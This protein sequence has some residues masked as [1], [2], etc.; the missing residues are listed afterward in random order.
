MVAFWTAV[1][2][3]GVFP[4]WIPFQQ[5]GYPFA[6][7]MQSGMN[8][9]PLWIFPA[10]NL[11]YT[12]RAAIVFQCLHVLV[13]AIGMFLLAR[14]VQ[15]SRRPG[16]SPLSRFSSSAGS[17]PTPSTSTSSGRSR[18]RPGCSTCFRWIDHGR[19]GC[20]AGRCSSRRSS[21]CF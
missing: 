2:R 16:S 12:L 3:D 1:V 15:Q 7:Q 17:I 4:Q 10:L 14:H 18:S 19:R 5:M 13:G 11:P 21:I 20:R 8:Y 6:L 9:L